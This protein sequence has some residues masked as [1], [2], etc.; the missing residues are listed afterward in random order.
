[1][2]ILQIQGM[3]K[4]IKTKFKPYIKSVQIIFDIYNYCN[5]ISKLI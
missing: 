4:E 2:S 3:Y 1:M 5:Y